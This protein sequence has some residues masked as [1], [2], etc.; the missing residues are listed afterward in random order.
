MRSAAHAAG[1]TGVWLDR[2]GVHDGSPLDVP[3]ISN[4]GKS[5][6]C[7]AIDLR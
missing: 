2:R 6:R 4:W 1:L 5:A 3:V 7:L